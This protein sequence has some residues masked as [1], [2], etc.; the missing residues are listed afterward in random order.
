MPRVQ[1][2][3]ALDAMQVYSPLSHAIGTGNLSLEFEDLAFRSLF[4]N[5]YSFVDPWLR[6]HGTWGEA[7]LNEYKCQ[8]F[9]VPQ[10]D[11]EFENMVDNISIQGRYK[12]HF[13]TMKKLLKDGR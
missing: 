4:P 12:I 11:Y 7:I 2:I 5:S 13:S 8:L 10:K 1:Q 3:L 6:N 9:E